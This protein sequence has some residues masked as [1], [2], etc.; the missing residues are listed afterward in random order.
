[1]SIATSTSDGRP[2]SRMVLL[3]GVVTS[4]GF[5]FFT[6]YLSRKGRE[7]GSNVVRAALLSQA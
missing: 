4:R 6:N 3:A 7:L 2:S 1:M 5:V